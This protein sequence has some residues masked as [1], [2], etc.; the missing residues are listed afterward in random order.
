[1]VLAFSILA[2]A[3]TPAQAALRLEYAVTTTGPAA[4]TVSSRMIVHL[5]S[6]SFSLQTG[7]VE[8]VYDLASRRHV[9]LDVAGKTRRERSLFSIVGFRSA[10][11]D[12]R[13]GMAKMLS[14]AGIMKNSFTP[15]ELESLFSLEGELKDGS[16]GM[17][18]EG[19]GG[20]WTF[21]HGEEVLVR[22]EASQKP[23]PET[24]KIAFS[25][26]LTYAA[27]MHPSIRRR[28]ETVGLVPKVLTYRYKDIP[29]WTTVSW[30]L[31]S[32]REQTRLEAA[33][34]EPAAPT[35][36]LERILA[37]V[38]AE[39]ARAPT[40]AEAVKFADEA[41]ARGEGLE[42]ML[43]VLEF[44]LQAGEGMTGETEKIRAAAKADPQTRRLMLDWSSR[45]SAERSLSSL[46]EIN[47]AKLKKGYVLDIFRS[48]GNAAL[49]QAAAAEKLMLKALEGNPFNAGAWHD[50]GFIYYQRYRMDRA[51]NCWDAGRRATP[52]HPAFEDVEEMEKGLLGHEG[53]F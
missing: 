37:L 34:L 42:A 31:E 45:E 10:E 24:R 33:A 39:G 4:K 35:D 15:F 28:L 7:G 14:S 47:G 29:G 1:M 50:L 40:E 12:N 2:L 3:S 51:W 27:S 41:L 9:T 11:L 30:R 43:A 48:N 16:A 36:T 20:N 25:R 8:E 13:L 19:S 21:Q 49:G 6:T 32:A 53:Y 46:S 17:K 5:D 44:G 52:R 26:W 18:A 38:S 23:V 22:Y